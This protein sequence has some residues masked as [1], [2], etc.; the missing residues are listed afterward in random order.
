[1]IK[2]LKHVSAFDHSNMSDV[3]VLPLTR[4]KLWLLEQSP[5]IIQ[6]ILKQLRQEHPSLVHIQT[7]MHFVLSMSYIVF[8]A[9]WMKDTNI[10]NTYI[11]CD[12]WVR[13]SIM[14]FHSFEE[15]NFP[16]WFK[17][18]RIKHVVWLWA[19]NTIARPWS[20]KVSQSNT[21]QYIVLWG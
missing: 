4:H 8:Q 7:N 11:K 14:S 3:L 9:K 5:K 2:G 16:S 21:V 10:I 17:K 6:Y 1:M 18:E 20:M 13:K 15:L 12:H 19:I